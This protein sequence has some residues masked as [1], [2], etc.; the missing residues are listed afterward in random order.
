MEHNVLGISIFGIK[1]F[2]EIST[3]GRTK[4]FFTIKKKQAS[5]V[6]RF[7]LQHRMFVNINLTNHN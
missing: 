5:N 2:K 3:E 6:L 4:E 1:S 7:N